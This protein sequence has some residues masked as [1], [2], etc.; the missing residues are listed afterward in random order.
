MEVQNQLQPGH[1]QGYG[2]NYGKGPSFLIFIRM[3]DKT[4]TV[5]K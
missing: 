4:D 2:I 3:F 5:V 1:W